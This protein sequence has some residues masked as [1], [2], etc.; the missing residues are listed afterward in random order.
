[1]HP[2]DVDES[3][4]PNE[5]PS[6]HVR[7]L[8]EAKARAC[9]P[10]APGRAVLGADT[11]VVV[12][13]LML[14]KPSGPDEVRHMLARLSGRAHVVL[15][16]ICLAIPPRD[17]PDL[18]GTDPFQAPIG[19]DGWR[20]FVEVCETTVEFSA[21]TNQDIEWY[22]ATGEP[23]DK[24][25]GYAIQGGA[26]RFVTRIEGSYTNV[27]GL[28]VELVVRLCKQVGILIS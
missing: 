14:G 1:M 17:G 28:P 10:F 3:R 9:A 7:R 22:L 19:G 26:S 27:V 8:A 11:V 5:P 18:T 20:Y 2:A 13:D 16:G 25:G 24:A 12:D 21:L 4:R 15:T 6:S 23:L